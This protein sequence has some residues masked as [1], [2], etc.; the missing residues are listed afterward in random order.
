MTSNLRTEDRRAPRALVCA[1]AVVATHGKA[2]TEHMVYDLSTTGVRLCG[3][4][5]A[6]LGDEVTVRLQL[7]RARVFARGH[8][9][10]VGLVDGRPD[11]AIEF[12]ALSANAEDTI[13][14]A[15]VEALS[16]PER[17]SVL[18]LRNGAGRLRPGRSWTGWSWLD[19]ISS[20]CDSATTPLEALQCLAKQVVQVGILSDA[21]QVEAPQWA[22]AYPEVSWRTL[23]RQGR[24]RLVR[25]ARRPDHS[26]NAGLA[27]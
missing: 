9:V 15:V 24:L 5:R 12:L 19:P 6:W 4:P 21:A 11:F 14:D 18:L 27:P 20:I 13:H 7:P 17:R 2:P 3:L 22:E 10:R 23:E 25:G 26:S 8:F 16:H 1:S